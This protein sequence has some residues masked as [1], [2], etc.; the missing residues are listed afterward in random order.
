MN[1]SIRNSRFFPDDFR[2]EQIFRTLAIIIPL[3]IAGNIIY[4]LLS[5]KLATLKALIDFHP[6]YLALAMIMVFV[7]WFTQASRLILWSRVFSRQ[8]KPGQAFKTAIVTDLG[9]FVTPTSTGG[10]YVK[11]GFLIRFGFKPGEAALLTLLGSAEDAIFFAISLPLALAISS[12]W[13]NRDVTAAIR[14]LGSHWPTAVILILAVIL[15]Y[16]LI[17]RIKA[18][19]EVSPGIGDRPGF[20]ARIRLNIKKYLEQFISAGKFAAANG[21][22]TL[23]ICTILAGIGWCCRYGAVTA[24]ILGL[25]YQADPAL[26]FLLQWVIFS[27]MIVIP[28]PGAIGGAEVTFALIMGSVVPKPVLPVLV[29][30]WRFVT[31]YLLACV[32]SIFMAVAGVG[33]AVTSRSRDKQV[34]EEVKA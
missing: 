22:A 18:K 33:T 27:T 9:N 20:I 24:L 12:A 4:V 34:I 6:G 19:K 28:T 2:L 26:Y 25:G 3:A 31:Y 14:N 7:P 29:G 21:K 13:N 17:F 16:L 32:G 8:L 5:S 30:A 11:L 23:G 10:G 1:G 15:A